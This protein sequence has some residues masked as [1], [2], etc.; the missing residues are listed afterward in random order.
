M[1]LAAS[2]NKHTKP[3][4]Q[5]RRHGRS[6]ANLSIQAGQ[7][8]EL[9]FRGT[10]LSTGLANFTTHCQHP[11]GDP[12]DQAQTPHRPLPARS[13]AEG[14]HFAGVQ[15]QDL[16]KCKQG[17]AGTEKSQGEPLRK[18]KAVPLVS[19]PGSVFSFLSSFVLRD[20]GAIVGERSRAGCRKDRA[21]PAPAADQSRTQTRPC[22]H[23]P[24]PAATSETQ[25]CLG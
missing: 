14:L 16:P 19:K 23:T 10:Q 8:P 3:R 22:T 18:S 17:L 2:L 7:S 13:K 15:M 21:C 6:R 25:T 5:M 20:V 9:G 11:V 24:I 4:A 1:G 12:Q